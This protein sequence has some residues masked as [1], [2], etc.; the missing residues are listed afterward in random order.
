MTL[1]LSDL[2]ETYDEKFKKVVPKP[3]ADVTWLM[4]MY[5]EIKSGKR[6]KK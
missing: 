3:H 2:Y 4:E 1:E 6:N 5:A